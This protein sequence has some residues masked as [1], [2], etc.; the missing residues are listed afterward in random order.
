[1]RDDIIL[2]EDRMIERSLGC[3]LLHQYILST[4][5]GLEAAISLKNI[6]TG[7]TCVGFIPNK[8]RH[9][10]LWAET[11]SGDVLG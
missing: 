11:L 2:I 6:L 5:D 3:R 7:S 9:Q 10:S 4:R 8:S 1:M